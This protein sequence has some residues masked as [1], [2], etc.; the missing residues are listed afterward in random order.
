M[1]PAGG[2]PPNAQA[3]APSGVKVVVK[4]NGPYLV[5]G[6]VQVCDVAGTVIKEGVVFALCRCGQSASKPFCDG[7]HGRLGWRS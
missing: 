3:P 7:S 5:Q 1:Q 4:P 6:N 2:P